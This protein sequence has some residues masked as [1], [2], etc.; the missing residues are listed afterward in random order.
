MYA[1][2]MIATSAPDA[3]WLVKGPGWNTEYQPVTTRKAKAKPEPTSAPPAGSDAAAASGMSTSAYCVKNPRH[4]A[5]G[6]IHRRKLF[7]L[8]VR[9]RATTTGC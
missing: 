7:R 1:A 2:G 8:V 6:G 3:R 5:S 9:R 4:M